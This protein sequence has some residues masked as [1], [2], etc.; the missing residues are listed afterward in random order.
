[1][2][3]EKLQVMSIAAQLAQASVAGQGGGQN[4]IAIDP[5][6]KDN[7]L[8][9]KNLEVW[10][11]FRLFYAAIVGA[12]ADDTNWAPPQLTSSSIVP[13]GAGQIVSTI[14]SA[15]QPLLAGNP[16]LSAID[17][18]VPKIL[19]N[20]AANQAAA[21]APP[22]TPAITVAPGTPIPDPGQPVTGVP[23]S[24]APGTTTPP[25]AAK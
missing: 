13:S 25:A 12:L 3:I 20:I 22:S 18:L 11:E 23:T 19:A 10:E 5:T 7:T 6:I 24:P 21:N 17:G 14:A 8:R 15:V 2:S 16:V 9:A 4:G 1:M